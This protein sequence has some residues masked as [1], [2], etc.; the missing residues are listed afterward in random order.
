M[1]DKT[2]GHNAA[3][4][5]FH[6]SE[7]AGKSSICR[8]HFP[9]ATPSLGEPGQ[10][11]NISSDFPAGS[12]VMKKVRA[13]LWPTVLSTL[14]IILRC[15]SRSSSPR[16]T[17]DGEFQSLAEKFSAK[18]FHAI[19][20]AWGRHQKTQTGAPPPLLNLVQVHGEPQALISAALLTRY[21]TSHPFPAQPRQFH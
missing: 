18:E 15:L 5:L 11:P 4:Y 6:T 9:A 10:S 12:E 17:N 20:E 2:V 1:V 16:P 7:P 13:A 21:C 8:E 14:R 19:M 3:S